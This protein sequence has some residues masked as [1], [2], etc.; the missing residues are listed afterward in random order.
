MYEEGEEKLEEKDKE[1][2]REKKKSNVILVSSH[3]IHQLVP[4]MY[5]HCVLL[6][7]VPKKYHINF[8]IKLTTIFKVNYQSD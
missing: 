6:L 7:C 3:I 2:K 8:F 5:Q 4:Q 1:M